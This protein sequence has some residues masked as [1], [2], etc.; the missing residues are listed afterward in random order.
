MYHTQR[1]KGLL[2][3]TEMAYLFNQGELGEGSVRPPGTTLDGTAVKLLGA[4]HVLS[5]R[6]IYHPIL[7]ATVS[8]I[9]KQKGHRGEM[10]PF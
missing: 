1:M 8:V 6:G 3:V 9:Q 4:L 7:W 10:F 2:T 5:D